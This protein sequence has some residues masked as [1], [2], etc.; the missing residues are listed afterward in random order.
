MYVAF[1]DP[2]AGLHRRVAPRQYMHLR[3]AIAM[4]STIHLEYD[5]LC[6]SVQLHHRQERAAPITPNQMVVV[7]DASLSL[8]DSGLRVFTDGERANTDAVLLSCLIQ[9]TRRTTTSYSAHM[10][11]CCHQYT[12]VYYTGFYRYESV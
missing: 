11:N 12:S 5:R 6:Q 10:L 1:S 4:S 3:M 9:Q 8:Y 7:F 2:V